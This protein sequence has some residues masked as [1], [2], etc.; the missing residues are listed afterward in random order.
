MMVLCTEDAIAASR[1]QA[2]AVRALKDSWRVAYPTVFLS[3]SEVHRFL[4]QDAPQHSKDGAVLQI[5]SERKVPQ[6]PAKALDETG[7]PLLPPLLMSHA[8]L[9]G[10]QVTPWLMASSVQAPFCTGSDVMPQQLLPFPPGPRKVELPQP[11]RILEDGRTAP[12]CPPMPK[13][14]GRTSTESPAA[15]TADA[16]AGAETSTDT[17]LGTESQFQGVSNVVA[18]LLEFDVWVPANLAKEQQQQQQQAAAADSKAA[19]AAKMSW[20][21]LADIA[22]N[23]HKSGSAA[24]ESTTLYAGS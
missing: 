1:A 8:D 9:V 11:V 18:K 13:F 5:G 10:P 17:E 21:P 7:M 24:S 20:D 16:G 23:L 19:E 6:A 22:S 3:C 2:W 12:S 15:A 14:V 4:Q